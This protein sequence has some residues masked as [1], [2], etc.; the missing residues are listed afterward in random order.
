V[1][2]HE[3]AEG[4][5]VVEYFVAIEVA[6]LLPL[7]SFTK[8]GQD[9]SSDIAGHA[10]RNAFEFFL[11]A[12]RTWRAALERVEFLLQIGYIGLLRIV[13]PSSLG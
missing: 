11:C 7:A 3:R 9:R 4:E 5:V 13:R 8:M 2:G 12:S 1:S 6:E 10:Q